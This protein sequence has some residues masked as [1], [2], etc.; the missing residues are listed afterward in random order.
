MPIK[1]FNLKYFL[2]LKGLCQLLIM[3]LWSLELLSGH[4]FSLPIFIFFLPKFFDYLGELGYNIAFYYIWLFKSGRPDR[5]ILNNAKTVLITLNKVCME[6]KM[7]EHTQENGGLAIP[8]LEMY[9]LR[10]MVPSSSV[11]VNKWRII[12]V[13]YSSSF[14]SQDWEFHP[15][16]LFSS[17][18]RSNQPAAHSGSTS[19]IDTFISLR[20]HCLPLFAP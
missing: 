4:V 11:H 2:D 6:E 17:S 20:P 5:I 16:L 9:P 1:K 10:N 7:H 14:P 19:K 8:L 12:W 13:Y 15:W 3:S 18:S